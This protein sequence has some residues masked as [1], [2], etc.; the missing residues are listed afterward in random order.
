[1]PYL[2]TVKNPKIQPLATSTNITAERALQAL[3]VKKST[4][5]AVLQTDDGE[6]G[7]E[8]LPSRSFMSV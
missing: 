1:M 8:P 5:M 3:L 6:Q 2:A 7:F 4:D